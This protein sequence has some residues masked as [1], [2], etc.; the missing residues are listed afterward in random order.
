MEQSSSQPPKFDPD[1]N[2][3]PRGRNGNSGTNDVQDP[4]SQQMVADQLMAALA[5]GNLDHLA[6]ARQAFLN[7][8]RTNAEPTG[9]D[10][11]TRLDRRSKMKEFVPAVVG[12]DLRAEEESLRQAE[13]ELDR[14]RVEV[15]AAKKR[16]EAEADRRAIEAA[17]RLEEEE[18]HRRS[19]ADEKRLAELVALNRMAEAEARERAKKLEQL[20]VEID[21]QARQRTAREKWM[22]SELERQRT[23]EQEQL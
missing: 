11:E 21:A 6:D 8:G 3:V 4:S 18:A 23:A 19:V 20:K 10:L 14:R 5:S 15:R 1:K 17:R 22:G 7:E 2:G 13:L 16:A 9:A 12:D